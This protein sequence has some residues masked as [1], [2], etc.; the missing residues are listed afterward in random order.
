MAT[1]ILQLV[2]FGIVYGSILALGAIGISVVFGILRFAHFAHGDLM[3]VG[4]YSAL[5]FVAVLD[6]PVLLALPAAMALTALLAVLIDRVLYRHFRRA[7]P[8]IL[9]ISSFGM[10]LALRASVQIAAGTDNHVYVS[11]ITLPYLIGDLRVKPDHLTI[12]AGAI[13][14]VTAFHLFLKMTTMGKAMRA[15]S[16]NPDLACISGID[17]DRVVLWTWIIAGSLAAAA[18]VFLA[19]DTRLN[20]Q[21]GW[22]VLLPMFAAAIV[23]G[24]GRPY[25]A[26][27]GGMV[28]GIASELSTLVFLPAYKPAVAFLFMLM[29]LIWRPRGI[30]K[31]AV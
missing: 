9:L 10:A 6:W 27:A 12:V 22:N 28:I 19:M 3:T 7:S 29:V 16:D 31:G 23:G 5:I 18:G 1:E 8:V 15:M 24:I 30:F 26:I 2:L 25:G 14:L 13:I 21:L 11:G 4:A 17:T 20:P